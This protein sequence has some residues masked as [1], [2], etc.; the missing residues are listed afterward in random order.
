M[1]FVTINVFLNQKKRCHMFDFVFFHFMFVLCL[2]FVGF[3]IS[4]SIPCF[5]FLQ[6]IFFGDL[7][8]FLEIVFFLKFLNFTLLYCIFVALK[9]FVFF[10]LSFCFVILLT[11]QNKKNE[12]FVGWCGFCKKKKLKKKLWL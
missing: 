10:F 11:F 5:L 12:N 8:V 7:A 4:F 9:F 1:R 6:W 2:F 3:S